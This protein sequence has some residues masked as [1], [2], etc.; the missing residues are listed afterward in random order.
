MCTHKEQNSFPKRQ[1]ALQ[2]FTKER[3][4]HEHYIINLTFSSDSFPLAISSLIFPFFIGNPPVKTFYFFK[5][6]SSQASTL[7][8]LKRNN[9]ASNVAASSTWCRKSREKISVKATSSKVNYLG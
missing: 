9:A 4:G 3:E 6:L 2:E 7:T 1:T 8:K 5:I